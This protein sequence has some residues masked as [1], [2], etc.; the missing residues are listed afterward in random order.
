M[1][2]SEK[3]ISFTIVFTVF[4]KKPVPDE[5]IYL[6]I[7]YVC[8]NTYNLLLFSFDLFAHF[9]FLNNFM[10][11]ISIIIVRFCCKVMNQAWQAQN[12]TAKNRQNQKV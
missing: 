10:T 1:A 4:R 3:L 5:H 6:F 2:D 12:L 8:I 7:M 9:Y 11:F